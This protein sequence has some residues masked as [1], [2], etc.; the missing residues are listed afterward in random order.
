MSIIFG[1]V[2]WAITKKKIIKNIYHMKL[3]L[4]FQSVVELSVPE[5]EE[6]HNQIYNFHQ[7]GIDKDA[8]VSINKFLIQSKD[9]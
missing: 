1:R 7:N 5:I 4:P 9:V 2:H 3:N 8:Q 6:D